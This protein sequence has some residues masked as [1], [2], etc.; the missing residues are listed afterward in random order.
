MKMPIYQLVVLASLQPV[1]NLARLKKVQLYTMRRRRKYIIDRKATPLE[2]ETKVK[3]PETLEPG[4]YRRRAIRTTNVK[5]LEDA[6]KIG[7]TLTNTS[8]SIME[9]VIIQI[10]HTHDNF[11]THAWKTS[12]DIWFPSEELDFEFERVANDSEYLLHIE[13][14]QGKIVTKKIEVAQLEESEK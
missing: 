11:E 4:V 10:G 3:I 13:D 5:L 2:P 14:R 12:V 7:M 8:G 9:D 6:Q 1:L